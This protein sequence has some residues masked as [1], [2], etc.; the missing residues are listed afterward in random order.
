MK[1]ENLNSF[2]SRNIHK[3]PKQLLDDENKGPNPMSAI[4]TMKAEKVDPYADLSKDY[5]EVTG[6]TE[7]TQ[8][9][10]IP[11]STQEEAEKQAL[12]EEELEKELNSNK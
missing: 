11:L 5:K 4:G 7:S 10:H 2:F 9:I 3:S 6:A 1:F 8:E 12:A